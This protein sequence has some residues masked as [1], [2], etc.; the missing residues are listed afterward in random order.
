MFSNSIAAISGGKLSLQTLAQRR[1]QNTT[2]IPPRDRR[3]LPGQG[4]I[5][6]TT[7]KYSTICAFVEDKLEKSQ[8]A[9]SLDGTQYPGSI[10]LALVS[11]LESDYQEQLYL[12]GETI[13]FCGY[14]SGAKAKVFE[15]EVQDRWQQVAAKFRL[16]E[17]LADRHAIDAA[18]YESLHRGVSKKSF[19][20]PGRNSYCWA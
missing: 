13:G 7:R 17:R 4:P 5:P 9:S 14:G 11:V 3:N 16:F 1:W 10:F 12:R 8:R 18:A 6:A 15:G 2:K 20:R 19:L